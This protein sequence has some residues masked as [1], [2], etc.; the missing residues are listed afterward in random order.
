MQILNSVLLIDDDKVAV[1]MNSKLIKGM[2]IAREIHQVSNGREAIEFINS[3][4][5]SMGALP[6]LLLVDM[7]MPIMSG[8][9]F[10]R[11]LKHSELLAVNKIPL[12]VLSAHLSNKNQKLI[13]DLGGF[14]FVTKPL[15]ASKIVEILKSE[16]LPSITNPLKRDYINQLDEEVAE[17]LEF[18][19]LQ[20]QYL[21]QRRQEI[22]QYNNQIREKFQDYKN[23]VNKRNKS[24]E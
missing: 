20:H 1:D 5:F 17:I 4:Y 8:P 6:S 15:N 18:L 13:H 21:I 3:S 11:E 22:K 14:K 2:G 12:A 19:K 24:E 7:A 16:I 9:E 23:A 10:I